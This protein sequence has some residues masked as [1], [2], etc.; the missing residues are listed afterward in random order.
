MT[1]ELSFKLPA[2]VSTPLTASSIRPSRNS[3]SSSV[4][5]TMRSM[6]PDLCIQRLSSVPARCALHEVNNLPAFPRYLGQACGFLA[7][8]LGT[9]IKQ[10]LMVGHQPDA[11]ALG[12]GD[13]QI[14]NRTLAVDVQLLLIQ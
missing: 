1:L 11:Q 10:G 12:I 7:L 9:E 2:P 4:A 3:T 6:S 13:F 14:D 8:D 5:V